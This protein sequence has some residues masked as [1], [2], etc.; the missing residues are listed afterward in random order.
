[1][2]LNQP[3]DLTEIE[4]WN[5]L[6]TGPDYWV[7]EQYILNEIEITEKRARDLNKSPGLDNS[8]EASCNQFGAEKLRGILKRKE[9]VRQRFAELKKE[10]QL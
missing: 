1:M 3:S 10:K 5:R 7:I 6:I 9:F 8:I 4:A 2:K